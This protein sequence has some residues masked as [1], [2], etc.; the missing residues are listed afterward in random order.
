MLVEIYNSSYPMCVCMLAV[1][2]MSTPQR[3]ATDG[4]N[5]AQASQVKVKEQPDTSAKFGWHTGIHEDGDL[6]TFQMSSIHCVNF[7]NKCSFFY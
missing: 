3:P 6:E 5:L 4:K 1:L 2:C 7:I